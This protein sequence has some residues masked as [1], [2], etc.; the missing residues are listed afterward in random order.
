MPS[1]FRVR[2]KALERE[3]PRRARAA[4]QDFQDFQAALRSEQGRQAAA[5]GVP[6]FIEFLHSVVASRRVHAP[7][8]PWLASMSDAELNARIVKL[9]AEHISLQAALERKRKS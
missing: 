9:A 1:D 3:G 2:L 8:P 5:K 6:A 7:P 4:E